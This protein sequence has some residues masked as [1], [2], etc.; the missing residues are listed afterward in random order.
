ML[1]PTYPVDDVPERFG[2]YEVDRLIARGTHGFVFKACDPHGLYVAIKWLKKRQDD[3]ELN[4]I[5]QLSKIV[6]GLPP[7]LNSGTKH[8]RTY[9]V[10]PY[11]ERRTLRFRLR[12][13]LFPQTIDET[14]RIAG[15]FTEVLGELHRNGYTHADFKPDNVLFDALPAASDH[16]EHTLLRDDERLVLSDFGTIRST[17]GPTQFGEGTLGYAAP[18]LLTKIV[19]HDA[20]VDIYAASA[21]LVECITGVAPDQI[22]GPA[23]SAFDDQTLRSTGPLEPTLRKAMSYDP[24]GRHETISEW[25]DA[26]RTA[27]KAV[28]P[29]ATG[30]YQR[31]T[32][33]DLARPTSRKDETDPAPSSNPVRPAKRN[34]IVSGA[35]V[36]F[37]VAVSWIL[38]QGQTPS[39]FSQPF[40]SSSDN[41][42]EENPAARPRSSR[43]PD[44]SDVVVSDVYPASPALRELTPDA[45]WGTQRRQLTTVQSETDQP[46]QSGGARY[47]NINNTSRPIVSENE[48]W[49]LARRDEAWTIADRSNGDYR[50][51]NIESASQPVWHPTEPETILHLDVEEFTL[52]S[53][54]IDGQTTVVVDLSERILTQLPEATYLAA[55]HRG[56]PSADG[57]RFAWA[58]LNSGSDPIGF[59]TYDSA[60]D[61]VLGF[62]V[63]RPEGDQGEFDSIAISK[64]GNNVV[65]AFEQAYVIYDNDFSNE[66]R[67]EQRPVNYE[68]ALSSDSRDVLVDANYDSAAFGTGWIVVHDLDGGTPRQLLNLYEDGADSNIQISG[69]ATEK[70]GWVLISTHD[71]AN[72]NAWSCDRIMAINVDDATIVNLA[73]TKSCASDSLTIPTGVVNRD[74]TK[75]WFNTDFGSCGQNGTIIELAIDQLD[76]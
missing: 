33:T 65:V 14:I 48:K 73:E 55:P 19:D 13:L 60:T 7:I 23:D 63:G 54:P 22:R 75:A 72:Q 34:L 27:G 29:L 43:Q 47:H 62:K 4:S 57:S 6:N 17:D 39:L 30:S 2:D 15:A 66:R 45:R 37:V 71:C 11:Y 31:N 59:V 12:E 69:L 51:L 24:R 53:T 21:T 67:I 38:T 32:S 52:L 41:E 42:P 28:E 64:S 56:A 10:M 5:V 9:Y 76:E 70:P 35:L 44:V 74:F 26:L 40:A 58:V 3:S 68:L 25:S 61:E 36:A 49:I 1:D 20:R 18:E 46:S 8:D 50:I 16:S